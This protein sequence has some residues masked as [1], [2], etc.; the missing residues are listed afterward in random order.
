MKRRFTKWMLAVVLSLGIV[1]GGLG[2]TGHTALAD[3]GT[4]CDVFEP[5]IFDEK[6]KDG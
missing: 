6:H 1:I 4:Y 3:S 2:A 5:F